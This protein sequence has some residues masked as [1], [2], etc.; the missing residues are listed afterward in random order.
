MLDGAAR[1]M[2]DGAT[3]QTPGSAAPSGC[4]RR[5]NGGRDESS[6][7]RSGY[8]VR[9]GADRRHAA[10]RHTRGSGA[11]GRR[12]CVLAA[13]HPVGRCGPA[14]H[15]EPGYILTPLERP[16][17]FA[18]QEYLTDAD[19]AALEERAS[20]RR[21][22]VR[23]EAGSVE[24]VEGAYNEA[25]TGRGKEV[26]RTRR[27][28]LIVDPPDGKIPFTPQG[29]AVVAAARTKMQSELAD[30]PEDR[31]DLDRC[32]GVSIPFISGTSGTYSRIV[33]TPGSITLYH[34]DG[35][36]GGGYRTVAMDGGR[37]SRAIS[38][39]GSAI[40]SG[41]GRR[42]AGRRHHQ[43]HRPDQLQRVRRSAAPGGTVH[44]RL[45]RP[46][47]VRGDR[48]RPGRLDARL[49]HRAAAAADRQPAEPDLRGRLP[50]GQLR[51]DQHP[52][53]RP[54]PRSPGR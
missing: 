22:D 34:E 43:L 30:G 51:H 13:P 31:R 41:T 3:P 21:R 5:K 29:Q 12:G 48:R 7:Y 16:D 23:A 8:G 9:G 17:E 45:G 40:R 39:S 11:G 54:R 19:V 46:D 15:L 33:Q 6:R 47:H 1:R 14:G 35:H 49:D 25:F 24:D 37:T 42:H 28:S 44:A 10:G 27:T 36:I 32:R 4:L 53:R 20:V 18:D 38:A 2:S 52:R 50:R 26:I